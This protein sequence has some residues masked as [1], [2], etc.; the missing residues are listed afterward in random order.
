MDGWWVD[1]WWVDGKVSGY[2]ICREVGL[3][4]GWVGRYVVR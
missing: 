4:G 1:W 3:V 2:V